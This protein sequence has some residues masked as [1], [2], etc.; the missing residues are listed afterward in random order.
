MKSELIALR[1][2]LRRKDEFIATLGH[3]LR[4]P[5]TVLATAATVI[6]MEGASSAEVKH[7]ATI[8]GRQVQQVARLV[9]DLL[10]LSRIDNGK[11]R[12]DVTAVDL[13]EVVATT[14]E[15][16]RADAER[17]H[18]FLTVQL[19]P[20]PV[21]V[22]A[23]AVR[24]VQVVSNLVDNAVKYTPDAGHISIA[25]TTDAAEAAIVVQ[26]DGTGIPSERLDSIFEP[27]VQLSESR[28]AARGGMGLGLPLVRRLTEMHGGTVDVTS[29]GC[30][31][32]TRFAV[33]LPLHQERLGI[34]TW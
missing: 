13:R 29:G 27:F 10:D 23:D 18:Q 19:T 28:D 3:E 17:R 30:G 33:H 22:D 15:A 5:L 8:I 20:D 4:N 34:S 7:A 12:L 1:S 25:V 32:G 26:D 11:L 14:L 6:T 21:I 16:R 9:N 2:E 24:L 31:C